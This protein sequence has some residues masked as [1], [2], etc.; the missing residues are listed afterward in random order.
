MKCSF[1]NRC[2]ALLAA[3]ALLLAFPAS[4]L[5][6]APAGSEAPQAIGSYTLQAAD[7]TPQSVTLRYEDAA[8]G[9][10]LVTYAQAAADALPQGVRQDSGEPLL[11]PCYSGAGVGAQLA[12]VSY[13]VGSCRVEAVSRPAPV[14]KAVMLAFLEQL[15]RSP[16]PFPTAAC[17]VCGGAVYQ[18]AA[19]VGAWEEVSYTRC[20]HGGIF[21]YNDVLCRRTVCIRAVCAACGRETSGTEIQEA[22]YCAYGRRWYGQASR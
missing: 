7:Q 15:Q 3:A 9:Q 1:R 17:A 10:M 5:A 19:D 13:T 14:D 18:Q 20:G 6:V 12:C 2:L 22:Y 11:Y 16:V 8:G 21:R 4:A